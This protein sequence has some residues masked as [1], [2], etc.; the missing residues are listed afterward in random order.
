MTFD[1]TRLELAELAWARA[2]GDGY[3]SISH[4]GLFKCFSGFKT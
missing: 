1:Y 3:L 4:W 2:D